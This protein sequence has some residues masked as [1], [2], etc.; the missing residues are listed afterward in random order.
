M[1]D[2]KLTRRVDPYSFQPRIDIH[3]D[4][5]LLVTFYNEG[6]QDAKAV[7]GLTDWEIISGIFQLMKEE[8]TD[9]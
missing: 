9:P 8:L 1:S 6:I 7:R 2:F 5:K 4:D 3:T